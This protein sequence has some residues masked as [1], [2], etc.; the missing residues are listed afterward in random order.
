MVHV[1]AATPCSTAAQSA[2]RVVREHCPWRADCCSSDMTAAPPVRGAVPAAVTGA[3]C[4]VAEASVRAQDLGAEP[5]RPED[6][7]GDPTENPLGDQRGTVGFTP[8]EYVEISE[9][10]IKHE[11][12]TGLGRMV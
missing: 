4:G 2:S 12:R 3:G 6:V 8:W 1:C 5:A 10:Q 7:F 9:E 11:V